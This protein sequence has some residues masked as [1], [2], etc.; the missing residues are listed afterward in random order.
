M[1]SV[2]FVDTNAVHKWTDFYEKNRTDGGSIQML[3]EANATAL[4]ARTRSHLKDP[5]RLTET[6]A[7]SDHGNM[8]LVPG[9]EGIM[10]LIH[11]GFA[12]NTASSFV[13]AFANGNLG[14]ST[15]FKSVD[16]NKMTRPAV[17]EGFAVPS[18]EG[19]M[20]AESPEEFGAVEAEGNN[21][22]EDYPNHC[23]VT[24]SIFALAQ[25][26]KRIDSK[27]LAFHII[28]SFQSLVEDNDELSTEKEEEA[29][30]LESTLALL[31]ASSHGLLN[32][33][34]LDDGPESTMVNHLIKG[35]RDKLAGRDATIPPGPATAP[36]ARTGGELASME[37]MAASSQS[38]VAL[39]SK[40]Q[41]GSEA[42]SRRKEADKSI[43]KTMGP[44]QTRPLHV[45]LHSTDECRAR[46]D[47]VHEEHRIEC[48]ATKGV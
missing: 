6:V 4:A 23:V 41:D 22:L 14:E 31:W 44:T 3:F 33:V 12:C 34:R 20:G 13:L 5:N 32:E 42:E 39:L 36:A 7:G 17:S 29:A 28:E 1:V 48:N 25:G 19:M 18:L 37:L 2:S 10:Q 26:S 35:V 27:A 15:T 40:F 11:H 9:A 24:P 30:G 21:I 47:R 38:M 46:D 43:F 8:I 45:S 16:R